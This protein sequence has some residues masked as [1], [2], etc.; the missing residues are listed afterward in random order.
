M[1]N[2]VI[3]NNI[4]FIFRW[5][6]NS[7]AGL[8]LFFGQEFA[9]FLLRFGQMELQ[10]FLLP[11]LNGHLLNS[12]GQWPTGTRLLSIPV[13]RSVKEILKDDLEYCV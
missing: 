10:L 13:W 7:V 11:W 5:H 6:S 12:G 8:F 1:S 2:K 3:R 4:F 9:P